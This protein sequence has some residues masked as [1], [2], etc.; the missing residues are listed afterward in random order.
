MK[1]FLAIL[2]LALCPLFGL[3][4]ATTGY[5]RVETALTR[6]QTGV[7]AQIVPN[8]KVTVTSTATGTAATIYS[9]PLLTNVISP[10]VVTADNFGNYSYYISTSYC[11][12]ETITSPG[13]GTRVIPNICAN[14]GSGGT[15]PLIQTDSINNANQTLLNFTDTAAIKFTNPSGG[16]EEA[17]CVTTPGVGT[18]GCPFIP[19]TGTGAPSLSCSIANATQTYF[20]TNPSVTSPTEYVCK[21][22][23]A[24]YSW[25][26]LAGS[27]QVYPGAGVPLSS[28]S[29]WLTSFG[30]QGTDTNV[31]TSGTVSGLAQ[32][33]CTDANGGATTF[34]CPTTLPVNLQVA[35]NPPSGCGATSGHYCAGPFYALAGIGNGLITCGVSGPLASN[36]FVNQLSPVLDGT[37]IRSHSGIGCPPTAAQLSWTGLAP[38]ANVQALYLGLWAMGVPAPTD[39]GLSTW[40]ANSV[41][42]NV[43]TSTH[44][45]GTGTFF[46]V[47]PICASPSACSGFNYSSVNWLITNNDTGDTL[48]PPFGGITQYIPVAYA[49]LIGTAPTSNA[50]TIEP[51]LYFGNNQLG[52]NQNPPCNTGYDTNSSSSGQANIYEAIVPGYANQLAMLLPGDLWIVPETNNTSTNPSFT[53]VG[54]T[55]YTIYKGVCQP[56]VANDI[57]AN[58]TMHLEADQ[59]CGGWVLENPATGGSGGGGDTITSPGSTLTV[60]GTSTNTTLDINLAKANTWT[61]LQTL[62]AG[63]NLSGSSSPLEFGGSAGTIGQCVTSA[64]SGATPTWGTCGSGSGTVSGQANGV[65]PL[66]TAATVIGAQSH[67]SDNG[68]DVLSSI[69]ICI[70]G[71][72]STGVTIGALGSPTNWTFDTT[73]PTT[74][75]DS[76]F[77]LT[78]TGSSCASA[79]L[80]GT[81]LNIPPCSGG[82]GGSG[83]NG[84]NAQ[85]GNYTAVSGDNGKTLPFSCATPCTLTLPTPPSSTWAIFPQCIGLSV[86]N[87]QPSGSATVDGLTGAYT[88][89]PG[90]GISVWTDGTNYFTNRGAIL[91]TNDTVPAF[92][93]AAPFESSLPTTFPSPV[94]P[95]DAIV[96]FMHHTDGSAPGTVSDA[97]G[98]TF[99]FTSSQGASGTW[100]VACNAIGGPTT[101]TTSLNWTILS[102]YE[103]SNV[104][105]SSCVDASNSND[106]QTGD[107]FTINTNSITTTVA[108]DLIYVGAGFRGG[109]AIT[110]LTEANGYATAAATSSPIFLLTD[111]DWYGIQKTTATI[112]DTITSSPLSATD[113]VAGIIAL[114]P[115]GSNSL[116]IGDLIAVQPTLSLGPIHAGTNK[117]VLTS[118][119]AG[120]M[121]SY[122]AIPT[123]ASGMT[124]GQVAIAGSASTITSSKVLAGSGAGI[125]TGPTTSTAGDC[126]E[127]TNTSG[128]IADNGSACGSGGGGAPTIT[129]A[130][131]GTT[132]TT[133]NTL[134]KL[135]GAPSTAVISATSDTGGV[136][137]I[138]TSG[139]GTSG[140]ATISIAGSVNCVFSGAT[141]SGDYVQISSA[142]GG[143]C[144]DAGASYPTTGQ[145]IGRVLST[146]GSAGTYLIDLFPSEIKAPTVDYESL[147]PFITVTGCTVSGTA[148]T[149]GSAV[150]SI[151]FS[152]IPGTF[153][154]LALG[155]TGWATNSSTNGAEGIDAQFNG[156]VTGGNYSA[157]SYFNWQ[158]SSTIQTGPT[159][160]SNASV[161]VGALSESGNGP[162]NAGRFDAQFPQYANSTFN[163]LITA[164]AVVYLTGQTTQAANY[165][166]SGYWLNHS[167]AITS[168]KIFPDTGHTFAAN[169]VCTF[170]GTN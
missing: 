93:Q 106:I 68:T 128:Q 25:Q 55:G 131:A 134:T 107:P 105:T 60:G 98:D 158:G 11:V 30:V 89:T 23:G 47:S 81:V 57:V 94:S 37:L 62:S 53:V 66:A 70:G 124:S 65:I 137:G 144:A 3:A 18:L 167:N 119:G 1:K 96:V 2:G 34:G 140:N 104:A 56:L 132:G 92:I 111:H 77:S 160:P 161:F 10:P 80:T 86:C 14:G 51:C 76:I 115:A 133:T 8:A 38:I 110:T 40:T 78:T 143:D 130:N 69:P 165:M 116:Q 16:I 48:T 41:S 64:G 157:S 43:S 24:S 58:Y 127:F 33:L 29:A 126:V 138:T 19:L 17:S 95:G 120:A 39:G 6:A 26:P 142:T 44:G 148:C 21:L 28:G 159:A 63:V 91:T 145:V 54:N 99:N 151:T 52:T 85:T 36:A 4:Q 75:L 154:N 22:V 9:D 84:V 42:I 155:C 125:T 129:I 102:A 49:D 141:T 139:A 170:E 87:I 156:D 79:S 101:I 20:D 74:A 123:V 149:V 162:N 118:N 67:L 72:P 13:Q 136:V 122:Q 7:N 163:R 35:Y 153:Q 168:I 88:M 166:Y 27:T 5:H 135:T 103:F 71:C 147:L 146:N 90:M 121:P 117:Y 31:L 59:L 169:T 108:N 109:T 82:G 112:S 15:G 150:S 113:F 45:V 100:A 114:K 12:T 73:T 152:S 32:S 50:I 46:Q 61:A 97:Q 164:K 83:L